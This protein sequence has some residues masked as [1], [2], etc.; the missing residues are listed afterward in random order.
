MPELS[1][2]QQR[3]REDWDRRAHED[4][5]YYV[6]FG[7]RQQ[8]AEEFFASAADVL[9]TLRAEY[10]RLPR[11]A[12]ELR[13]LEIGCGP[14]RLLL[15]L[16]HDFLRVDGVD[17]SAE[18]VRIA[19]RNLA[20]R[21]NAHAHAAGGADLAGFEDA[22]IGL[23]YSYAVFQHIPSRDVVWS[24]LR[25][26]VRVLEPGGILKCQVNALPRAGDPAV[27]PEP[28]WSLRAGAP[29]RRAALD[30]PPDTWSGVSFR[31][32]EL[33]AFCAEQGLQLL[34]FDGF[35]TQYLWM[36]ARKG[37]EA[38]GADRP[39]RLA[40]AANTFTSDRLIPQAGRFAS[41][42]L[43]VVDLPAHADLNTLR[44]EIDGQPT[45][46]S[47]VRRRPAAGSAQVNVFLPPG[48]RTGAVP[49]RLLLDGQPLTEPI[50]LRVTPAAPL[51]PRLVSV[52]DGVNLLSSAS[53]E[54]RALKVSVEE[55]PYADADGVRRDFE[56]RL[57]ETPLAI[58]DV[59]CVDPLARRFEINLRVPADLPG[60]PYNLFC[61]LGSRRLPQVGMQLAP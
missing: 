35:D 52:S 11:P 19:N 6:A 38:P 59:F 55:A 57:D 16:S 46:P 49:A 43:W 2:V 58:E 31:A 27:T 44:V 30:E 48:T 18:M 14:G 24:Y 42:S 10:E 15:P 61:R 45:A 3:M 32:E 12:A 56:A 1:A 29:P 50:A 8:S 21:P 23:V 17:V 54:S 25:E 5:S 34:A 9:R 4:A 13:A 41:A 7:R 28:G 22:S 20:D 37:I 26:A 53:I 51:V 47:Y 60:G 39:C 36:T 40:G 33:A